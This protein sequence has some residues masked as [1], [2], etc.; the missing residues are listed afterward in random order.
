MQNRQHCA[1][2]HGVEKLVSLPASFQ[3]TRFRLS[4]PDDAGDDQGRI[5]KSRSISVQQCIAQFSAFVNRSRQMSATVARYATGC[6]ELTKKHPHAWFIFSNRM[7]DFAVGALQPGI[8]VTFRPA[9]SRTDDT[10]DISFAF[11]DYPV[12]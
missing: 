4:I 11:G 10:D 1:V 8:R 5:V 6:R 7:M 12:H 9:L 2:T 3:R